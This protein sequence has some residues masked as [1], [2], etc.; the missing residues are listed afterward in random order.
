MAFSVDQEVNKYMSVVLTHQ[1]N[2]NCPFCI[3]YKKDNCFISIDNFK[4]ALE[5]AAQAKIEHILLTG[6]EPTLH[7]EILE[8]ARMINE[9]RFTSILTTNYTNPKIT[10]SLDGIIDCFNI[11]YYGQERLPHQL[12][13]K[14]DI[15]ISALIHKY[16][17]S[18]KDE[19]DCFMGKCWA[20]TN[21]LKFSTLTICNEWTRARQQVD[22]L[23]YLD[24]TWH[25]LFNEILGQ[26]YK[27]SIIKRYD[28]VINPCARQSLKCHVDGLINYEW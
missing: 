28:K 18:S 9:F 16:Q 17:L 23:D 2:K 11:S 13:F 5:V 19:L 3:D 25:V 7:P 15:T 26:S 10:Q 27:G 12:D 21:N 20:Y 24:C 8:F 1:C 22:Y 4:N 6:G 14:S